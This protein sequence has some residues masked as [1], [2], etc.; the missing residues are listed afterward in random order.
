LSSPIVLEAKIQNGKQA[1]GF[2]TERQQFYPKA[3]YHSDKP[4]LFRV[5][6]Q[7]ITK[8][9]VYGGGD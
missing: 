8:K 7:Y 6:A 5:P 1:G 4:A 3:A 9:T 2:A